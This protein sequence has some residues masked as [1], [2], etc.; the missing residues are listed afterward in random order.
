MIN[1]TDKPSPIAWQM[2]NKGL[3]DEFKDPAEGFYLF[4]L[5]DWWLVEE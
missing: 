5:P 1:T 3:F 2:H 4:S